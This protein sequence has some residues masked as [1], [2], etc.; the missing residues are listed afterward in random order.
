MGTVT[1]LAQRTMKARG[2]SVCPRCRMTC[3]TGQRI[4]LI[5][6]EGWCHIGCCLGRTPPMIGWASTTPGAET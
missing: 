3:T 4:G 6:G 2:T 1:K 5:P